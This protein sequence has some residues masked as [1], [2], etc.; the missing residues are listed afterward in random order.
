MEIS[1]TISLKGITAAASATYH[2]V[3]DR[4]DLLGPLQTVSESVSTMM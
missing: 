1:F 4:V 3:D 2:V